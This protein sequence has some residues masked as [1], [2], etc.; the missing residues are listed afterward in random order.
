MKSVK[1]LLRSTSGSEDLLTAPTNDRCEPSIPFTI[2]S[3]KR[4]PGRGPSTAKEFI[5]LEAYQPNIKFPANNHRH[6]C[7]AWY[8]RYHR[9]PWLEFIEMTKKSYCFVYLERRFDNWTIAITKF[10]K[11]QASSSHKHA[12]DSWVN[13]KENYK[14][15]EL[16]QYAAAIKDD[17]SCIGLVLIH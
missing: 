6:F 16:E 9:Y 10:N 15:N 13:A 17:I 2:D 7:H 3:Y 8:Q 5:L 4:D 12:N 11:H 1:V 14:N